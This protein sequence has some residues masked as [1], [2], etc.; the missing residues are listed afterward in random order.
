MESIIQKQKK[1]TSMMLIL[2]G[3]GSYTYAETVANLPQSTQITTDS[4][5]SLKIDEIEIV[6]EIT[7][8]TGDTEDR[9]PD[10]KEGE[11]CDDENLDPATLLPDEYQDIPMAK[12]VPCDKVN[13]E[14][15]KAAKLLKD[16][17]KKIPLAK[18]TKL[19]PCRKKK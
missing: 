17:Y 11:A 13:C 9:N 3:L 15:L 14:N 1:I 8:Q 7:I 10:L 5:E 12:T 18:T 6:P 2:I 16:T 19:K 4:N